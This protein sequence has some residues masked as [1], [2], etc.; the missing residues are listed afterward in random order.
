[1]YAGGDVV[2][3][4]ESSPLRTL[5][6]SQRRFSTTVYKVGYFVGSLSSTTI[7]RVLSKSLIRLAPA[8]LEFTEIPINN[9]PLY[10]PDFDAN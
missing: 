10:N 2:H 4:H 5:N 8:G 9:L 7:N 3:R 1:V 6:I